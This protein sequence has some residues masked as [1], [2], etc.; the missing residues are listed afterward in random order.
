[1]HPLRQ[2]AEGGRGAHSGGQHDAAAGGDIARFHHGHIHRTEEAVA[3]HLRHQRQVHVEE[4]R[5][6]GVDAV[7]QVGIG[8][9]GRAETDRLGFGQRAIE[10]RAGRGAGQDAD[11]EL[12]PG[13]VRGDRRDRQSPSESLSARRP[14]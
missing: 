10:R 7:A 9:V 8:L 11:L 4:A 12:L 6:A 2:V 5:L 14:A 3:R 13:I 1:M